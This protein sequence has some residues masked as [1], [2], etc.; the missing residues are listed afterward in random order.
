MPT[1]SL[2]DTQRILETPEGVELT[3]RIAGPVPRALAW[4]I[5]FIFR[6]I[7]YVLLFTL[8]SIGGKVGDGLFLLIFFVMEWFYPVLFEV[9]REG[10]TPGKARMGLKVLYD[11]GTPIGWTGSMLRNLLRGVD[12]LPFL[13]GFGFISL[14]CTRNFQ[15]LGDL[16]AGTVV[17]YNEL[18]P[19]PKKRK[20]P[21]PRHARLPDVEPL[22]LPMMLSEAEQRAVISFAERAQVLPPSRVKELADL[23][24][25]LTGHT[26]ESS[27]QRLYRMANG[28]YR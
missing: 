18:P 7:V 1:S 19:V 11:N 16:A 23:A 9:Y 8:L 4:A 5:D 20:K 17:V 10:V 14:L 13:Y 15:R 27:A 24:Q 22:A 25:D 3:L 26:G 12:S 28:L 6:A 21:S 2:L